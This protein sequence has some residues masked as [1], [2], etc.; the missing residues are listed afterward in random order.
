MDTMGVVARGNHY[1][2]GHKG[3][4]FNQRLHLRKARFPLCMF[5]VTVFDTTTTHVDLPRT[6]SNQRHGMYK[7]KLDGAPS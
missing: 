6:I 3:M 2:K 1:K 5:Y 7:S 4:V